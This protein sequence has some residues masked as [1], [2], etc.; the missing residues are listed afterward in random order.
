MTFE[1]D[2][3]FAWRSS[4]LD[5]DRRWV[6]VL[7]DR[8]RTHLRQIFSPIQDPQRPLFEYRPE[9]FDLGSAAETLHAALDDAKHRTGIALIRGLPREGLSE[10]QFR[11]MTWA[12]GLHAGVA[13]PQGK[14]TQYLSAVRDAGNPYRTGTGRGYSSNAELD[15]HTDT[16]DLVLLSCF[17]RAASGG[18]SIVTSSHA[19]WQ[20][21]AAERPELCDW[22]RHPLAF[23]RQGEE[24]PDEGPFVIQPVFDSIGGRLFGRWNWNRMRSAQQITGAPKLQAEHLK[25]LE[26]FDQLLRRPDLAYSMWL[27]PGDLQIINSHSTVHS[28]TE[29][30]DHTDPAMKRL[31]FRLWI[32]PSDSPELPDSWRDL[33]RSTLAGSVRGGLRGT[34]WDDR[35][36]AFESR[37]AKTHGLVV[38]D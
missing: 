9:D 11:L 25:A 37:Q 30:I 32:A 3:E 28:R 26:F 19:A 14:S 15:Y 29:F 31:L 1:I 5:H 38:L 27:E 2:P 35:C 4:E 16:A 36:R 33:Y 7:G 6:R 17:N 22:L 8:A 21:L 20:A 34:E 24:A 12:I 23:S 10:S 18:M 13:R